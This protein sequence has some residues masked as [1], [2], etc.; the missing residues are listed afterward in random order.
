MSEAPSAKG[1]RDANPEQRFDAP[2]CDLA[3]DVLA[4]RCREMGWE[5]FRTAC[6]P[7][8]TDSEAAAELG[9][10]AAYYQIKVDVVSRSGERVL[11]FAA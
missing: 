5:L 11:C 1:T 8:R 2:L 3:A 4:G 9:R 6:A 7:G 10:W